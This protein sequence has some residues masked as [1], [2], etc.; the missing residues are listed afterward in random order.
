MS[1]EMVRKFQ[2]AHS[3]IGSISVFSTS[4][5]SFSKSACKVVP[6]DFPTA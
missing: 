2:I 5:L 1:F 4:S 6:A 3:T